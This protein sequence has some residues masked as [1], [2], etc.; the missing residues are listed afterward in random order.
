[1]T[2]IRCGA[3]TVPL[4]KFFHLGSHNPLIGYGR[5]DDVF[6][7]LFSFGGFT[8]L[9]GVLRQRLKLNIH[10]SECNA[11]NRVYDDDIS[12]FIYVYIVTSKMNLLVSYIPNIYL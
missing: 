9:F 2:N 8:H 1:M 3:R 5:P 12:A 11:H 6:P 10:I 4:L 7:S